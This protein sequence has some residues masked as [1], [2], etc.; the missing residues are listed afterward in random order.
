[1]ALSN[2]LFP[3][4]KAYAQEIARAEVC[5]A[6]II[7]VGGPLTY[8]LTGSS[9][10]AATVSPI[11][12]FAD[13]F[14]VQQNEYLIHH[15]IITVIALSYNFLLLSPALDMLLVNTM[16][17]MELS[18]IFLNLMTMD[19]YK[20]IQLPST[21]LLANNLLFIGCFY[22]FR[23]WD[24]IWLWLNPALWDMWSIFYTPL[25]LA[26]AALT[27]LNLFWARLI[28]QK[29]VKLLF[30]RRHVKKSEGAPQVEYTE[31]HPS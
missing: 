25:Y 9:W 18:T 30:G 17:G 31:H 3:G 2:A 11:Y 10:F 19:R 23:V 12:F 1:M 16:I 28:A 4:L 24:G 5:L 14:F 6:Q 26:L 13:M 29:G 7:A 27:C 15:A 21:V 20:M 8:W 22:K